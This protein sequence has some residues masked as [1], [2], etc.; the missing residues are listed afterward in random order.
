MADLAERYSL[1][2]TPFLFGP[3]PAD[4][5]GDTM[6]FFHEG[7]WHV[8]HMQH[9]GDCGHRVSS[10]LVNWEVR[11]IA[12]TGGIA[13][14][15]VVQH[16]G[17]FWFFY[18]V[19]QTVHLATSDDLDHWT[20]LPDNPVLRGDEALYVTEDFRD[21]FVFFNEAEGLWW[22]L[23]G[24][25]KVGAPRARAGCVGLFKSADL[26]AW[27]R[28]EPLW[29]PGYAPY[30]DCPQV[31]REAGRYYL[32]YL[33][34]TTLYRFA[35]SLAGPWERAPE[36][37][38]LPHTAFAGSRLASDGRRWV[39]FPF[40]CARV[41]Q[42]EFGAILN[43]QAYSIPRQLE[44]HPDGTITEGPPD[45]LL[46][47]W[48]ALP[49]LEPALLPTAQSITGQWKVD[50]TG[51]VRTQAGGLLLIP[52]APGD[53]YLEADLTLAR[54]ESDFRLFFRLADDL[55]SGYEVALSPSEGL[56]SLR[57]TSYWDNSLVLQTR[58]YEAPIGQPIKLRLVVSGT[59]CEVFIADQ[60]S[61]SARLYNRME[62]SLAFEFVDAPGALTNLR[63]RALDRAERDV[64]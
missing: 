6:P 3:G 53:F 42:N 24:T 44:F 4:N 30:A 28:C 36:R 52:E 34:R 19:D 50:A 38:L 1:A 59:C 58:G 47:A 33:Q 10:D 5:S 39:S 54:R 64:L 11:P 2:R 56:V 22:L 31:I 35:P 32:L 49:A 37:D 48:Q 16:E 25:R 55:A 7:L 8:F 20:P 43:G 27:K 40:M 18:T 12:L 51:A 9:P 23:V 15:S 60:L 61:L 63:L 57:P 46:A 45:E 29:G 21:P 62:G 26:S 41:D 14:G 13:T 17:R